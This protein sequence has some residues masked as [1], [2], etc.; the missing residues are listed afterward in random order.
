MF[1]YI[2]D[3]NCMY[4]QKDCVSQ[5]CQFY[6]ASNLGWA[7]FY[8]TIAVKFTG[9]ILLFLAAYCYQESDKS[10][11]KESCRTLETDTSESVKMSY[12]KNL[13]SGLSPETMVY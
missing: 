1:G 12:E 4:W 8:F 2:I 9:G 5:K 13:P 6:N 11:G 7:F 10:N 3:V